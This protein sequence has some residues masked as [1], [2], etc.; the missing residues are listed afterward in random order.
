MNRTNKSDSADQSNLHKLGISLKLK[1]TLW[2]IIKI[3][4]RNFIK[5]REAKFTVDGN[6]FHSLTT[7]STK[8]NP[9]AAPTQ[10]YR[11][12]VTICVSVFDMMDYN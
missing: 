9:Q 10:R 12:T 3:N 11:Y 1:Y 4:I 8:Q 5:C 2:K 6:E 7:I